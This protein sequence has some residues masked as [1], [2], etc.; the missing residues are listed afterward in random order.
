MHKIFDFGF[1]S[2]IRFLQDAF[3]KNH[4][5]NIVI[6][7]F[8]VNLTGMHLWMQDLTISSDDHEMQELGVFHFSSGQGVRVFFRGLDYFSGKIFFGGDAK[9]SYKI[10]EVTKINPKFPKCSPNS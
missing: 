4:W 8:F 9:I 2:V 7:R 10:S 1:V 6:V 5:Q 3:G